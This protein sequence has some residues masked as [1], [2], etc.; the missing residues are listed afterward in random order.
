MWTG[1]FVDREFVGNVFSGKELVDMEFVN[2]GFV[3]EMFGELF[4]EVFM[5]KEFFHNDGF[6]DEMFVE[7]FVEGFMGREFFHIDRFVDGMFVELFVELFMGKEFFH[8]G[9]VVMDYFNRE[10]GGEEFLGRRVKDD[11]MR[12]EQ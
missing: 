12:V 5:G 2:N 3:D 7:L 11:W 4:V 1:S 6:V 10:V 8:K 9:F